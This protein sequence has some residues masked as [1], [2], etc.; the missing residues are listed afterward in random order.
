ML[1]LTAGLRLESIQMILKAFDS[2]GFG[3]VSLIVSVLLSSITILVLAVLL[4][5]G[6]S[7]ELFVDKAVQFDSLTLSMRRALDSIPSCTSSIVLAPGFTPTPLTGTQQMGDPGTG[8]TIPTVYMP[9]GV[10]PIVSNG[11]NYGGAFQNITLQAYEVAP[12]TWVSPLGVPALPLYLIAL[13]STANILDHNGAPTKVSSTIYTI[14]TNY[15]AGWVCTKTIA[16]GAGAIGNRYTATGTNITGG[17]ILARSGDYPGNQ[18]PRAGTIDVVYGAGQVTGAAPSVDYPPCLGGAAFVA[19]PGNW[20]VTF[21]N[22][23][24]TAFGTKAW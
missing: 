19:T 8:I 4:L 5:Q 9:D 14:V 3:L 6:Q 11:T 17:W 10:T 12:V 15:G 24:W 21:G 23:S 2:K 16:R 20:N 13:F 18:P 1:A 22:G 7:A